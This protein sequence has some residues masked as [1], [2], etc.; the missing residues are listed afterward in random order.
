MRCS[1]GASPALTKHTG[2]V[3]QS[4]TLANAYRV[5][6]SS[7]LCLHR[8][9]PH[10]PEISRGQQQGGGAALDLAEGVVDVVVEGHYVLGLGEA[11]GGM[12][13]R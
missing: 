7:H 3:T 10:L 8:V 12:P 9:P 5:P 4:G 1:C 11:C 2:N 6:E 13:I